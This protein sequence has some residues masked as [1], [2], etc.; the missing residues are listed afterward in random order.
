MT[1]ETDKQYAQRILFT[2]AGRI[3]RWEPA[4]IA[5]KE[6]AKQLSIAL[7]AIRGVKDCD[8]A[9][10]IA[11]CIQQELDKAAEE[12]CELFNDLQDAYKD[13][14]KMSEYLT[15]LAAAERRTA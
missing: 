13:R 10:K 5:A 6:K 8:T 3:A 2:A 14:R 12:Y 4:M 1:N 11:F 9:K 15:A 7:E